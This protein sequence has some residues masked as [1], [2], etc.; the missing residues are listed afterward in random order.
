MK[1]ITTNEQ[2]NINGGAHYHWSCYFGSHNYLSAAR[3]RYSAIKWRD[4]HNNK[5][6]SGK[7]RAKLEKACNRSCGK[8]Y[9]NVP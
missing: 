9:E 8:V 5:Y 2:M 6:H 3:T 1:R 4:Y 7:D